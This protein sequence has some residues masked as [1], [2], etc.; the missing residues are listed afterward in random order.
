MYST[1]NHYAH[2]LPSLSS[3]NIQQHS[4]T[5]SQ[6]FNKATDYTLDNHN[7]TT[8]NYKN[9][10]IDEDSNNNNFEN[11]SQIFNLQEKHLLSDKNHHK[12]LAY[13]PGNKHSLMQTSFQPPTL[14]TSSMT[15]MKGNNE[16]K[17]SNAFTGL[18]DPHQRYRNNSNNNKALFRCKLLTICNFIITLLLIGFGIALYVRYRECDARIAFIEQLIGN[19]EYYDDKSM[20][21]SAA[22]TVYPFTEKFSE[23]SPV[24]K[25]LYSTHKPSINGF[26]KSSK[27]WPA[28]NIEM[29]QKVCRGLS[30]D[31]NEM[32]FYEGKP[33]PPGPPGEPGRPGPPGPQGPMGPPGPPGQPGTPGEKGPPGETGPQGPPGL[34]GLIGLQGPKGP[35][36]PAGPP[37]RDGKS[38]ACNLMCEKDSFRYA[39]GQPVCEVKCTESVGYKK[40]QN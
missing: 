23:D 3:P 24:N 37:G 19:S 12:S 21:S 25:D 20:M 7:T 5:A 22:S 10:S 29:F 9:S 31:C 35:P 8:N 17:Q 27:I 4:T 26:A 14:N 1:Q 30:I 11:V 38:N 2:Q 15:T 18:N 39:K 33:G 36:G 34:R 40:D 32:K 28:L 13:S 6:Y 16:G